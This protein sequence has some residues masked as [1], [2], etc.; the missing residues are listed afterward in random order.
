MYRTVLLN[1]CLA[2]YFVFLV[3]ACT[4]TVKA[5]VDSRSDTPS[6]ESRAGYSNPSTGKY[7]EKAGDYHIVEK[8]DTLYSIAWRYGLD[9]KK[10]ASWNE[11]SG[12]YTIYPGQFI[13]LKP[14]TK[15]AQALAAGPLESSRKNQSPK[16]GPSKQSSKA[17]KPVV[18]RKVIK[19]K[20]VTWAWPTRGK[21]VKFNTPTSKKG[22]DIAGKAGQKINAA[23]DGDVVYSGSGLLGYGKLIIIK[24]NDTYLSAY[25]HNEK[26]YAKEGDTVKAGQQIA[27]MGTG[28]KGRPVLHFEIRKDGTPVNPLSHLPK[29]S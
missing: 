12:R 2:I 22:I 21:L 9:Y 10:V 20:P 23:A 19:A 27:T 18:A 17:A 24:H 15:K 13:R 7:P 29:R 5:P 1:C 4:S 6:V 3:S 16:S 11:I 8:G 28:N 14:A 26:I 25:A